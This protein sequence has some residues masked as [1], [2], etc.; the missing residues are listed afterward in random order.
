MKP[1]NIEP[2]HH[3]AASN[4]NQ[5]RITKNFYDYDRRR[6]VFYEQVSLIAYEGSTLTLLGWLKYDPVS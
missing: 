4:L 3:A 1:I 5:K 2:G 6:T